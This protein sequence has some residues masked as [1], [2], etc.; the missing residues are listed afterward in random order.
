MQIS[1]FGVAFAL[2]ALFSSHAFAENEK[3]VCSFPIFAEPDGIQKAENFKLEFHRDTVTGDAFIVGNLGLNE[4]FAIE[5]TGGVT[6]LENLLS[7]AV[8]STTIAKD[9]SA[10]HSRHTIIHVELVPSQYYG[11]CERL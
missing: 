11:T 8:Q 1:T 5:G 10:V 7:G 4:V 9:N 3:Y 2:V 6:F